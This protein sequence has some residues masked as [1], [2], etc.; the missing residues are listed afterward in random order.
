MALQVTRKEVGFHGFRV[1]VETP[2]AFDEVLGRLK[3]L[4][5][6]A[7]VGEGHCRPRINRYLGSRIRLGNPTSLRG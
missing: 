6:V 5:G 2:L 4:T 3:R 1:V 7:S